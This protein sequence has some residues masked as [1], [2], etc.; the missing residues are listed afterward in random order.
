VTKHN[1]ITA[2]PRQGGVLSAV[3]PCHGQL[4]Y[5]PYQSY[6]KPNQHINVVKYTSV[7]YIQNSYYKST[8]YCS[9]NQLCQNSAAWRISLFRDFL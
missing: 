6:A 8:P 5:P 3:A 2:T 7:K 4:S 1:A 9:V